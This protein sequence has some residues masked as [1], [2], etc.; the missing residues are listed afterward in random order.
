MNIRNTVM[1]LLVAGMILLAA[2]TAQ[3]FQFATTVRNAELNAIATDAGTT[4]I[5]EL[6]TGSVPANCAASR[7]G[8]VL[9]DMTLPSTWMSSASGGSISKSGTWSTSSAAGTGTAGYFTLYKSDGVTCEIQGS[10]T[11]TGS[12]GDM[13]LDNTSIATGQSVTIS[14]FSITAGNP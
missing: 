8:T 11:A 6:R 13:T 3:A 7:T 4:P 14:S 12:G 9:A 5:L 2:H 1:R 10:V